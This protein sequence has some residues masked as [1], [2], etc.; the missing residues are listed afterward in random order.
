MVHWFWSYLLWLIVVYSLLAAEERKKTVFTC[1]GNMSRAH[2]EFHPLSEKTWNRNSFVMASQRMQFWIL[3]WFRR[4]FW[5]TP[6]QLLLKP[7][8]TVHPAAE[9][10]QLLVQETSTF[11]E[12]TTLLW[13]YP[14][15]RVLQCLVAHTYSRQK[16]LQPFVLASVSLDIPECTASI[17]QE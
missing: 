14:D 10:L 3:W 9:S 13:P 8:V 4:Y 16:S 15:S 6:T 12:G 2:Q 7:A 5:I 17:A 11:W 1:S